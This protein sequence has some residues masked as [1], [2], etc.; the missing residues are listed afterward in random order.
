MGSRLSFRYSVH[1]IHIVAFQFGQLKFPKTVDLELT[2]DIDLHKTKADGKVHDL[3]T[4]ANVKY[5]GSLRTCS[6]GSGS[7]E[8]TNDG[9]AAS[10]KYYV[11]RKFEVV[12]TPSRFRLTILFNDQL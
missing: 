6:S 7:R 3:T 9:E 5:N 10:I 12:L 8:F 1:H 11:P 2:F 4:Y